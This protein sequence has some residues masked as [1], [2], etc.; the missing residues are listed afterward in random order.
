MR[1]WGGGVVGRTGMKTAGWQ[2]EGRMA[3]IKDEEIGGDKME[4]EISGWAGAQTRNAGRK[5][6][7]RAEPE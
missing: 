5:I 6:N 7:E 4:A 2:D 3:G 1:G